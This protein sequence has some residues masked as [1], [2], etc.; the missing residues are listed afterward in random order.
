MSFQQGLSGLNAASK[1]LE[2]IGNN[3]ANASTV[4]F[5]G[6]Q[7][8]FADVYATSLSG[9]GSS[10]VG[11]G[12]KVAKV[13]QQFSQ[14]N[15]TA[16]NNPLDIAINGAGFFR[17]DSNG[18]VTY[19]RNGQFELDKTGAIVNATGASLTG[20]TANSAGVLSTGAPSKLQI[21]TADLPPAITAKVK[22]VVNLDSG[23]LKPPAS[24]FN[25]TDPTTYNNATSIS[26]FDSLGNPHVMQSFF[27]KTDPSAAGNSAW[28]VYGV[29][30]DVVL[31]TGDAAK[32]GRIGTLEFGQDGALIL[33]GTTPLPFPV[34]IPATAGGAAD[35]TP[36][37]DYTGSTQYG[38]PFIVNA[39]S[40]DGYASGRLTG[41]NTGADGIITGR[42][43]NG[44]SSTLGQVVL[45]NF[46]NVNGLQPLGNNVWAETSTSG[47]PLVGAPTAGTFGA[48]QAS[49]VEDSNVDLTAELVNM[50]TAQR[51]YQANA[52]T[53]KTQDQVLQ[54]LVNLR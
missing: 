42:Y 54:T 10:Q 35:I 44:K 29:A 13:S 3:V 30:D 17:M 6:S 51:V 25:P 39:L 49:A 9:G 38:S 37:M 34:T 15:I 32:P 16:S 48:L 21:N 26:V 45:A 19:A 31:A 5:K 7:A 14:G 36:M 50:I 47:V 46:T 1:S 8:Q 28:D 22:Q 23:Q 18:S 52:Q 2:V 12:T 33:P 27:V 11:I 41:F 53:V 20:Y 24:P 4:G 40:Q 43:S